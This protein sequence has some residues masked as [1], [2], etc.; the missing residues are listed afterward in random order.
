MLNNLKIFALLLCLITTASTFA[1]TVVLRTGQTIEGTIKLQNDDVVIIQDRNG[2]KFQYLRTDVES[3][4]DTSNQQQP[5]N[6]Q[7][8][9]T[10]DKQPTTNDKQPTTKKTSFIAELM[11]GG[12]FIPYE[13]NGGM[14]GLNIMIGSKQIKDFPVFLGGGIGYQAHFVDGSTYSILP[15]MLAAKVPA[16]TGQHT[17]LFGVNVGYGV[18]LNKKCVGG[19]HA[20]L[21]IGYR[22]TNAKGAGIYI[23]VLA[24][25]QQTKMERTTIVSSSGVDYEFNDKVGRSLVSAA[26]KFAFQF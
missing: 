20:G 10:N 3:V 24:Q 13:Q 19:L 9:T 18:G 12:T 17:P 14:V 15:I 23:G 1:D 21:D 7:T 6:E 25:F 5:T 26:L 4:T 8:P 11:G 2:R 16:L 22:Y